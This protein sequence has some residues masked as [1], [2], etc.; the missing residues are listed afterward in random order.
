MNTTTENYRLILKHL[1][2]ALLRAE[3]SETDARLLVVS[4]TWPADALLPLCDLGH[5]AF[6]ESR[7]QEAEEKIALLPRGLEWHFIGHIQKN[8]VRRILQQ[9][10]ILHGVDS[11]DLARRIDTIAREI[12]CRPGIFLEINLAAEPS[13][14]GFSPDTLRH[15]FAEIAKLRQARLLGL[16]A[17]PPPCASPEQARPW[18]RKLRALRD[19]LQSTHGVPLP[20]LSMGMSDDFEVAIE[21]GSTIVRVGSAIFGSRPA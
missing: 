10:G 9:F 18:F 14:D 4:K 1:H 11:L 5:R 13:K 20:E 15:E 21:E 7:L 2:N 3:R 6:G 19:E 17:I 12:S 16:M 8:K